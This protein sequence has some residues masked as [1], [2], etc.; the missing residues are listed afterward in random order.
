LI[1]NLERSEFRD[2][3]HG[4]ITVF[5]HEKRIID[6]KEFQR[7]RRI[8]QLGLESYIYHGAE[9]SRFGHS[10][11]VMHLAGELVLKLF[12]KK[13]EE[14]TSSLGDGLDTESLKKKLY[15]AA[16]LAGLLHDIGHAPFSHAGE[17]LFEKKLKHA[18][19]SVEIIRESTINQLIDEYKE[20]TAVTTEDVV[21]ILLKE[22]IY[23]GGPFVK[24]LIDS[25]WDVDKMDYLLRDSLYCGVEYG[26][27]DLQRLINTLT[28]DDN[29]E[30]AIQEGGIHAIEQLILARYFMF[31]QVY[32]HDVRRAFDIMLTEFIGDCLYDAYK[33][34]TYPTLWSEYLEWDDDRIFNLAKAKA[35][36][37]EKN[38]AWHIS[39]RK[40]LKTVS[41]TIAHPPQL[42]VKR[43]EK[44]K[45]ACEEQ[46]KGVKFWIDKALDHP[47]KFTLEDLPVIPELGGK[48][49]SLV[50][51]CKVLDGLS[52]I[53][54]CRIYA[55]TGD[56]KGLFKEISSYCKE[57]M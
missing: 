26:K 16:R 21:N 54:Q 8:H 35:D 3:I 57:F 43:T 5:E 41:D 18:N 50:E 25:H 56:D 29:L 4:F 10:L 31:T 23:Y 38:L 9:H 20:K 27:Y 51:Q 7:L 45:S 53:E 30:L 48:P 40:H 34:R 47:E 49:K 11:G 19:Y 52:K 1:I 37:G 36:A 42:I 13:G 15:L 32:F 12:E 44:L 2:P 14:L 28:L 55:D 39:E 24:D 6:T 46:F 17:G 22:G 33:R